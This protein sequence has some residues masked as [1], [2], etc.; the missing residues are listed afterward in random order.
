MSLID[1]LFP[2]QANNDY[3][4][5]N[6]A[7]YAFYLLIAIY[8]FRS[9]MHFLADDGGINSIASIIIFPFAAGTPDP[10]NVI[11]LF[12]SL[13]GSAQLITLAFFYI[14]MWRYR[15]L[16][17]LLWLT[18]VAE[19]PMRVA[20]GTMHPLSAPYYE[21]VPPGALSNLPLL[22]IASIMLVL[23]LQSKKA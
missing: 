18:V 5:N 7:L 3:Q 2:K 12:A 17:P 10:N 23:S 21:H 16:L 20:A 8:T 4:G 11:Y 15:N 6:I 9:F 1:K 13:W 14:C 19:V 22:A